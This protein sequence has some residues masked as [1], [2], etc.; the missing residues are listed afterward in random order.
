MLTRNTTLR[1]LHLYG[2]RAGVPLAPHCVLTDLATS[3]DDLSAIAAALRVA[4]TTLA[5]LKIDREY[6][7]R[8]SMLTT[9]CRHD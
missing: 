3:A 8:L 4:N 1:H 5:Q 6:L 7:I 9:W 2:V